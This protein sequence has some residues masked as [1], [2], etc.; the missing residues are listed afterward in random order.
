VDAQALAVPWSKRTMTDDRDQTGRRTRLPTHDAHGAESADR[1]RMEREQ[2][3]RALASAGREQVG[4]LIAS[5]DTMPDPDA[6]Q[7]EIHDEATDVQVIKQRVRKR[8]SSIPPVDLV[9]FGEALVEEIIGTLRRGETRGANRD[10]VLESRGG[11]DTGPLRDELADLGREMRRR[12]EEALKTSAAAI[13]AVRGEM[14]KG[15]HKSREDAV[16]S[17]GQVSVAFASH[18]RDYI[19][20]R[21]DLV[22]ESK[23]DGRLGE[24]ARSLGRLWALVVTVGILFGG[25]IGTA[26]AVARSSGTEEGD[27]RSWRRQVDAERADTERRLEAITGAL[28][29]LGAFTPAPPAPHGVIP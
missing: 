23:T 2:V 7:P 27:L 21:A 1:A 9:A 18:E 12:D 13:E 8:V 11:A 20:F 5:D 14:R 10:L 19:K 22:G 17:I 3:D 28:W 16:A 4:Q 29:R 6:P 15:D 26:V 24:M 25:A